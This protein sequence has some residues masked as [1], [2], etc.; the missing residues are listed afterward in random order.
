MP[1]RTLATGSIGNPCCECSSNMGKPSSRSCGDFERWCYP[2]PESSRWGFEGGTE[3]QDTYS[4]EERTEKQGGED[5]SV[6]RFQSSQPY[7]SRCAGLLARWWCNGSQLAS[8]ESWQHSILILLF[9]MMI[10]H[11][12]MVTNRMCLIWWRKS[13]SYVRVRRNIWS[14]F[15]DYD[16]CR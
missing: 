12:T 15:M 13:T 2:S 3:S 10:V 4:N 7:G 14:A 16:V 11:W 6:V 1:R 8:V 9:A 5:C